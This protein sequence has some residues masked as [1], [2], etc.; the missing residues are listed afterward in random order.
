MP[1]P[2]AALKAGLSE[3]K[4]S[5]ILCPACAFFP[6]N[7]IMIIVMGYGGLPPWPE[8]ALA[9]ELPLLPHL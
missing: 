3:S 1:F 2:H 5:P 8:A 9:L 6:H 4:C 7:P